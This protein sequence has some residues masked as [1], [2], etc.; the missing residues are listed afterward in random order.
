MYKFTVEQ[1]LEERFLTRLVGKFRQAEVVNYDRLDRYYEAENDSI[2]LRSMKNGKPNNKIAHAYAGYITNMATSYFMGKPIRYISENDDLIRSLQEYLDESY[3]NDYEISKA[4]SKKGVAFEL[5]YIDESSMLRNQKYE[6]Q[7]I[8]PVYSPRPGEF[9]ECAVHLWES[10]DIDGNLLRDYVDVYD[11]KEIW[12]FSRRDKAANFELM[13]IEPHLLSDV[14][15]IVYWN[16]EERRS[17]YEKVISLIDAYDRVESNTANDS[18][19]FSEAYLKIRGAEGGITDSEG[20]DL[21]PEESE[22]SLRQSRLL[23]LPADGDTSFLT[24]PGDGS[25]DELYKSRLFKDIFFISQ[26][27]PMTDENFSGNLSGIAIKYKL[28]GLEQLAIMKENKFRSAQKKK[29]SMILDWINL[30]NRKHF[31]ASEVKQIYERNFID[32]DSEK[33]QDAASA[34]GIVSRETQLGMMPSSIVPDVKQEIRRLEE[35]AK[36]SEGIYLEPVE[37]MDHEDK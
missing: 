9:L 37:D 29:L 11:K 2:R 5:L 35:E 27:P 4:A 36:S 21:S 14:P 32:N 15:V 28:I 23:Y 12:H 13:G 30:K 18:D 34:E 7:E 20:N 24:K 19:Y 26:V 31:V 6:A 16:N 8:I 10:R 17:D 22:R 25:G 3:S 33:I 1:V